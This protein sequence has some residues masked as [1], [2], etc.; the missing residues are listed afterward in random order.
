MNGTTAAP[1]AFGCPIMPATNY[2]NHLDLNVPMP[3]YDVLFLVW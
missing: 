1:V 3:D 2:C